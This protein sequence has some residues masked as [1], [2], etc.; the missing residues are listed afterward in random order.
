MGYHY[1]AVTDPRLLVAPRVLLRWP[2]PIY[3][4]VGY[5]FDLRFLERKIQPISMIFGTLINNNGP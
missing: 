4:R 5:V 3:T 2:E 1:G